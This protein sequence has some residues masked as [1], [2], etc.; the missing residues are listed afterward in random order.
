LWII[1]DNGAREIVHAIA[2][3]GTRLGE[4]LVQGSKNTDWEDLASFRLGHTGYLMI[5]DIG[6][7]DAIH[8]QRSLFFVEEPVP[9]KRDK[10][11]LGWRLDFQYP[12]GPRDAESA[13]V[14]IDARRALILSKRDVPPVLYAIP[15]RG[16]PGKTVVATKLGA[17]KSLTSPTQQDVDL[18]AVQNDWFW[19]PVGMD[20]S[21][22]NRAAVILTYRA[23]FYFERRADQS[24]LSA[25]NT[26]PLQIGLGDFKNAEAVAF[27][28]NNRT[29]VVTG[30]NKNSIVLSVSLKGVMSNE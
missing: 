14:D 4:F 29:V 13:A 11:K 3:N 24:W 9:G 20:I 10:I 22:D 23:V 5:A 19:Q 18:A 2:P 6:D 8:A 27:G 28:D 26:K 12:D 21:Q 1:N 30:E 16:E 15:L 25:L 7:N 17:V